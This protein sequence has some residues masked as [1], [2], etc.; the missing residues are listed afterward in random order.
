MANATSWTRWLKKSHIIT[1][2]YRADLST[3]KLRECWFE[4][5]WIARLGDLQG[6]PGGSSNVFDFL[7]HVLIVWIYQNADSCVLWE[8]PG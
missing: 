4:V 3:N 2:E 7:Q 8:A 6:L 1:D 5:I